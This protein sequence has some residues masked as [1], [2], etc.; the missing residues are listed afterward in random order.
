V[1]VRTQCALLQLNRSTYYNQPL[2]KPEVST[3]DLLL[4]NEIDKIYTE[5]PYY[6]SRRMAKQLQR[7][8]GLPVNR[9]RVR[10][11]MQVMGIE[12]IY[13]KPNTSKASPDNKIYPYLLRGVSAS[14]PNHIWGVDITYIRLNKEWM[15]LVAIIDWFSRFVISWEL[16]D[17]LEVDFCI[18]TLK[19]ALTKGISYIHNSD[20]GSQFTALEYIGVLQGYPTIQISMDGRGRAMDNIFTE[21]LWRSVK[22]EEVYIHDYQSPRDAR[23]SLTN[24][25]YKYN[26]KRLHQ[27]ISYQTPAEVYYKS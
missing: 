24:Y 11:L 2:K 6:G 22:Y 1:S 7:N 9:K 20:Q 17:T 27:S 19:K 25:F 12:A 21:R 26:N 5:F 10:R 14:C 3:D 8:F 23:E 13:P 15:Y 4:M 16:S 18:E